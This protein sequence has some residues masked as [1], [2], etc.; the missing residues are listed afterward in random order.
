VRPASRRPL[1]AA[2]LLAFAPAA[3]CGGLADQTT[4]GPPLVTVHGRITLAPGTTVDGEVRLALAWY[5]GL[6]GD[7]VFPD[8]MSTCPEAV[9]LQTV[10]Q[11]VALHPIFPI[12]YTFDVVAPPPESAQQSQG[13]P[14]HSALGAL[15]AYEDRNRNGRLDRCDGIACVDRILGAS[16][17]YGP[18]QV[19]AEQLDTLIAYQDNLPDSSNPLHNWGFYLTAW[20]GGDLGTNL[21]PLPETPVDITLNTA[22]F[23]QTMACDRVCVY[24]APD[25]WCAIA[26]AACVQPRLP[27]DES[28]NCGSPTQFR[29]LTADG[30]NVTTN[31]YLLEA[32]RAPPEWWPCH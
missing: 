29:W 27:A 3:G 7:V 12:D 32:G 13:S 23:L 17:G 6:L 9:K 2:L 8:P 11:S 22:P 19:P 1:V 10:A 5:P 15:V 21:L 30:C 16:G 4:A 24:R 28:P 14:L 26:D 31:D 20:M 25:R 18:G